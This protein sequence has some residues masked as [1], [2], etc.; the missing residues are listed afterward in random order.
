MDWRAWGLMLRQIH[1]L[2]DLMNPRGLE[3]DW[4]NSM[5]MFQRPVV[6]K[7]GFVH[8]MPRWVRK[9]VARVQLP[10][11]KGAATSAQGGGTK[12]PGR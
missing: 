1:P 2:P 6:T 7:A 12:L 9:W 3:T 4:A 10:T 5:V 11:G 8:A